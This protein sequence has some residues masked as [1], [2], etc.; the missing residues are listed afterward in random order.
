MHESTKKERQRLNDIIH[1]FCRGDIM[2]GKGCANCVLN[3]LDVCND[4]PKR[5]VTL[6]QM[7]KAEK[8]INE[9]IQNECV[10]P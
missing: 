9:V 6:E 5:P 8:L 1:D 4:N 7:R 10:K 2:R 3:E